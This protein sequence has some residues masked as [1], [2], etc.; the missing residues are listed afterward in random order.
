MFKLNKIIKTKSGEEVKPFLVQKNMV[1]CFTRNGKTVIK[2]LSDFDHT[3]EKEKN[4]VVVTPVMEATDEFHEVDEPVVETNQ[5]IDEFYEEPKVIIEEPVTTEP[6]VI[7]E[8]VTTDP[9]VIIE[10]P[11][12]TNISDEDYI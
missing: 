1:Y 3:P 6:E 9:E 11:V 10:K 12:D 8:P 2:K 4:V 7:E 5:P